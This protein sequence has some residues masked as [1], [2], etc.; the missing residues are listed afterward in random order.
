MQNQSQPEEIQ[1]ACLS[2]VQYEYEPPKERAIAPQDPI[3]TYIVMADLEGRLLNKDKLIQ[4]A[5]ER[6]LESM[7][8]AALTA[9][10]A[11]ERQQRSKKIKRT[12]IGFIL[13]YGILVTVSILFKIPSISVY[14]G[15]FSSV[16]AGAAAFSNSYKSGVMALSRLE[17]TDS[18]GEL[19]S[20]LEIQDKD[21]QKIVRPALIRILP[22]L[23][24]SDAK[25]ISDASKRTLCRYL[26]GNL[27]AGQHVLL[28]R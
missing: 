5:A 8:G 22:K 2:I 26:Q 21:V 7:N 18:I 24:A 25:L 23:R 11:F 20:A 27:T 9:F 3:L 28:T 13:L 15:I 12:I 4:G 19:I 14:F 1:A 16:I 17:N 6:Q 10:V